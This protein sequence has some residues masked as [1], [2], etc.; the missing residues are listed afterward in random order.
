[1]KRELLTDSKKVNNLLY[2]VLEDPENISINAPRYK[3]VEYVKE[4]LEK[5]ELTPFESKLFQTSLESGHSLDVLC[6]FLS[7]PNNS[8]TTND[9]DCL[10]KLKNFYYLETVKNIYI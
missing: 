5:K 8:L 2:C 1:M 4:V 3:F 6:T 10:K 7:E 9:L